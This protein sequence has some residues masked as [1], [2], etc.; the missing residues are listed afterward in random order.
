[1]VIVIERNQLVDYFARQKVK[2]FPAMVEAELAYNQA[3]MDGATALVIGAEDKGLSSWWASA[4]RSSGSVPVQIPMSSG[5]VDSLNASNA[6]AVLL[7]EARRQ[8]NR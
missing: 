4:A 8:K 1:P 5:A 7:F 3:D 2:L 6:A